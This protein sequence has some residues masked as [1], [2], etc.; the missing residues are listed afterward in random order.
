MNHNPPESLPSMRYGKDKVHAAAD[1]ALDPLI[2]RKFTGN[3]TLEITMNE[4]GIRAVK[5]GTEEVYKPS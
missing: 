5:I 4:G 2:C 3:V 1:A